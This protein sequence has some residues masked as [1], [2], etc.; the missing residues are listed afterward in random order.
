MSS[1]HVSPWHVHSRDQ[2]AE[3]CVLYTYELHM[4]IIHVYVY[5]IIYI[6]YRYF[7]VLTHEVTFERLFAPRAVICDYVCVNSVL[8]LIHTSC[9]C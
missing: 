3:R 5:I 4:Y 2:K 7:F 9:H 1:C 8:Y 6:H